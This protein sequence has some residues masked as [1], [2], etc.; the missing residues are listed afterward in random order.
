MSQQVKLHLCLFCHPDN[1]SFSPSCLGGD[2][3]T[4]GAL[5]VDS[6]LFE[7]PMRSFTSGGTF[8][9]VPD[10]EPVEGRLCV[11]EIL[12]FTASPWLFPVLWG[13]L[14]HPG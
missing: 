12:D 8:W 9:N 5:S 13:P 10:K 14:F 4:C 1:S 2:A 6:V 7:G 11:M 3:N